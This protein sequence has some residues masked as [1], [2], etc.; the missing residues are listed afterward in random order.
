MGT[1]SRSR[2]SFSTSTT[3]QPR[4]MKPL[5]PV[6]NPSAIPARLSNA[7]ER[8]SCTSCRSTQ[9]IPIRRSSSSNRI[10]P[11]SAGKP[12]PTACVT[13]DRLPPISGP[14]ARPGTR[15][16]ADSVSGSEDSHG[17][18]IHHQR[19]RGGDCGCSGQAAVDGRESALFPEREV[20]S[21]DVTKADDGLRIRANGIEN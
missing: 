13:V 17:F 8:R 11:S 19:F 10:V 5:N 20:E 12:D 16:R 14:V 2:W 3:P 9:P 4:S 15:S 7:P 6:N 1:P 21:S 18:C